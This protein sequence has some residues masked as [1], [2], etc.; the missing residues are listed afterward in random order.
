M[1]PLHPRYC[2]LEKVLLVANLLFTWGMNL[3]M[4][5]KRSG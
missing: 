5:R 2:Q 1:L 3:P 4:P